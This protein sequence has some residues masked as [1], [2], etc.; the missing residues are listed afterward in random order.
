MDTRGCAPLTTFRPLGRSPTRLPGAGSA[1]MSPQRASGM[2]A[3]PS[4][5]RNARHS[6]AH[7]RAA[8]LRRS[9]T[10]ACL[11]KASSRQNRNTTST[12]SRSAERSSRSA[13]FHSRGGEL[14]HH[15]NPFSVPRLGRQYILYM[16][17]GSTP[18]RLLSILVW[19]FRRIT[20]MRQC[21]GTRRECSGTRTHC[22]FRRILTGVRNGFTC[23]GER[24]SQAE[25][26]VSCVGV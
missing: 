14:L 10:T 13:I 20:G 25:A 5:T 24:Q 6:P 11:P 2:I 17:W 3:L 22:T 21:F 8:A 9:A 26:T 4:R 7:W 16:N 18:K 12:A 19:N 23:M 15:L 1:P